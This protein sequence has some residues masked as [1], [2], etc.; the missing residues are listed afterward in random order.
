MN[1][2]YHPINLFFSERL[3]RFAV[4]VHIE[5]QLN[6]SVV[7]RFK[8]FTGDLLQC[9][10]LPVSCGIKTVAMEST[11]VYWTTI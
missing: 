8:T 3:V 7:H 9:R 2:C 11:S 5:F 6:I 10:D 1:L 4:P